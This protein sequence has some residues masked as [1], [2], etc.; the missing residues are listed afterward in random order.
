MTGIASLHP[1]HDTA[2]AI[3]RTDPVLGPLIQRIG[4]AP[5]GTRPPFLALTRAIVA[6]QISAKAAQAIIARLDGRVGLDPEKLARAHTN[7]LRSL[8]LSLAKTR[9]VRN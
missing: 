8:G 4:P 7:T 2:L 9:Y 5:V 3:L 1:H 6:Q